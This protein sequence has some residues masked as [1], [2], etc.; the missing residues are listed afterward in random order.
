MPRLTIML[1]PESHRALKETAAKRG[2]TIRSLV[3]E[4]LDAYGIKTEAAAAELVARARKRSRMTE[5][6]ALR[7]AVEETRARRRRR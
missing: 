3:Q 6:E 1:S 5:A 2:T 4:S 7:L